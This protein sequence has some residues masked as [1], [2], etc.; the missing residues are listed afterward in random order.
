VW[1]R[2]RRLFPEAEEAEGVLM[3]R[4][5]TGLF[6]ANVP[7]LRKWIKKEASWGIR[8]R[9]VPGQGRQSKAA[10][11]ADWGSSAIPASVV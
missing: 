6:Y 8:G 4:I 10:W 3:L 9:V 11:G 2:D 7:P 5:D 1:C